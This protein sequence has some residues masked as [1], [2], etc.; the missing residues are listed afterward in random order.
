MRLLRSLFCLLL[1]PLAALAASP[2]VLVSGGAMMNGNHFADSTLAAMRE[3]YAGCKKIAL[4]IHASHPSERDRMEKRL[5]EAFEHLV[6][7][8][9][10]SL[11]RHDAAGA[12]ALL[13][14]ADGIFVGGGE[15]FVLLGELYR[16]GQLQLIRDR[17]AA[18]IPYG[19]SSAG[20][21]VAGQ[22][23]GTTNDF[24]VADIPSRT[25]L[26]LL[27]VVINPHHPAPEKKA[28]HDARAGKIRIYLQFN[29]TET[30]LALADASIVRLHDGKATL[31]AGLGWVYRSGSSRALKPGDAVP[32]AE[33]K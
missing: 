10:E 25:S 30:V 19:G 33:G 5:Q 28:D 21:N 17:V 14:S 29:P 31:K 12:K 18:G 32:E 3:H 13:E 2:S 1:L 26:G 27:P 24:P 16:T 7:A 20:A 6:G 22:R 4:V 8:K 11:H 23:I 15:T 9:A